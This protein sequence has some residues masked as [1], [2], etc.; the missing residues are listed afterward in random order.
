MNRYEFSMPHERGWHSMWIIA[1][2]EHEAREMAL[3]RHN[4]AMMQQFGGGGDL[5]E[6]LPAGTVCKVVHP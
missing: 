5:L 2:S 6:S 4:A 3:S 1:S